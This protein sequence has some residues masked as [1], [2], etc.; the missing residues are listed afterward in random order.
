[1]I[2]LLPVC[3]DATAMTWLL[4]LVSNGRAAKA[5]MVPMPQKLLGGGTVHGSF[6]YTH[7]DAVDQT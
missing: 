1:M 2:S 5:W 3:A 4:W 6:A 7:T